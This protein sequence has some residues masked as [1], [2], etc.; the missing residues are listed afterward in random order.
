MGFVANVG[1]D[2]F[3][4]AASAGA[5]GSCTVA[6]INPDDGTTIASVGGVSYVSPDYT[7]AT[8]SVGDGEVGS[9]ENA[10]LLKASSMMFVPKARDQITDENGTV[11]AIGGVKVIAFGSLYQCDQCVKLRS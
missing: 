8:T 1:N 9:T 2:I 6:Q 10:F 11:W 3:L 5:V 7:L 4:F